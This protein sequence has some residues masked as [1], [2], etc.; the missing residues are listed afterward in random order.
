MGGF[1]LLFGFV[2]TADSIFCPLLRDSKWAS[3]TEEEEERRS[4]GGEGGRKRKWQT[5]EKDN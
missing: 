1:C 4:R 5:I 3:G 2:F